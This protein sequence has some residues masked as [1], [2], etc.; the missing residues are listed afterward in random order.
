MADTAR[1]GLPLLDAAQAQKHVTVNEALTRLDGL[2][3]P[4]L[5]SVDT[6][7]PPTTAIDGQCFGVPVGAVNDWAGHVGK[8]AL[9][10]N[11]GWVFASAA[12]G[13]RAYVTDR[14]GFAIFD[15]Q[16]W[17]TGAQS[18]TNGGASVSLMTKEIDVSVAGGFSQVV[19]NALPDNATVFAV[20]GRVITDISGSATSF[21]LGVSG[22]QTRYGSGYGTTPGA[23]LRGITGQPV[24]YYAPEDLLITSQGGFLGNGILRLAIH[25]MQYNLP[26][27]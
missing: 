5:V 8:I 4:I 19:P 20:T 12:Q 10:S 27:L 14:G 9:A 13:Y 24:V 1:L 3:Q 2:V 7:T 18:M 25:Y 17:V 23:Y 22:S 15:G 11:G 16:N 21:D 26:A 6:A